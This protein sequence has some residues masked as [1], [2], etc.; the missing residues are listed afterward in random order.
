MKRYYLKIED[1]DITITFT[2]VD[3]CDHHQPCFMKQGALEEIGSVEGGFYCKF[4]R[5]FRGLEI[6]YL[7]KKHK[8]DVD[9][10]N[11]GTF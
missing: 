1:L 10:K 4:C 5:Y 11:K 3:V 8:K 9:E 7:I 2:P 6:P